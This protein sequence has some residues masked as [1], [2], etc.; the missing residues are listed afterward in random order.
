MTQ[1]Y[2][3]DQ[4]RDLY[5]ESQIE[6]ARVASPEVQSERVTVDRFVKKEADSWEA[7]VEAR[8]AIKDA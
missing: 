7:L 5:L 3:L 8:K 4:L 2:T 1:C 6:L